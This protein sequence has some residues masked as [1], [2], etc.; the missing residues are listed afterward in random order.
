MA[1]ESSATVTEA[2]PVPKPCS[3]CCSFT[4]TRC[5]PA[6]MQAFP[7]QQEDAFTAQYKGHRED[8]RPQGSPVPGA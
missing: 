6:A 1:L 7:T 5:L 4:T 3:H 2:G 8:V